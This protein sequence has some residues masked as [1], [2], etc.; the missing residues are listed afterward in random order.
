M[1]INFDEH[2]RQICKELSVSSSYS[3]ASKLK[4]NDICLNEMLKI[5]TNS[6]MLKPLCVLPEQCLIMAMHPEMSKIAYSRVNLHLF[7]SRHRE[8]GAGMSLSQGGDK[9]SLLWLTSDLTKY[10]LDGLRSVLA[11][12]K[13]CL[14]MPIEMLLQYNTVQL[15]GARTCNFRQFQH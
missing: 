6:V 3:L 14:L 11:L 5:K 10:A 1:H 8:G 13:V 12:L 2:T 4:E 9:I 15:K 7:Q